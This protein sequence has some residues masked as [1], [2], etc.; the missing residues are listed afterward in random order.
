[1]KVQ[2][3]L[4]LAVAFCLLGLSCS[5]IPKSSSFKLRSYSEK[6][7]KNGL[8]VIFVSDREL[9]YISYSLIIQSGTLHEPDAY[10]GVATVVGELLGKGTQKGKTAVELADGFASMG[11]ELAVSTN[12]D[13][14]Y[15][16]A[17]SLA[18]FQ[19]PLLDLFSEAVILPSFDHR[20]ITRVKNQL[21]AAIKKKADDPNR[22]ADDAFATYLFGAHPYGRSTLGSLSGMNGIRKKQINSYYLKYYRPNNAIL[23]VVGNYDD[24]VVKQVEEKFGG[25]QARDVESSPLS[26]P[27][28]VTGREIRLVS[29][30]DLAQAQIHIGHL[31]ITRKNPDYLALRLANTILGSDFRLYQRIRVQLGLTYYISSSF[32][33]RL[34][35]GPFEISTFTRNEKIGETIGETIKVLEEFVNQGVSEDEVENAKKLVTGLFPQAIETPE[36]LALNLMLLRL[37]GIGDNYLQDFVSNIR[38]LSSSDIN[39][40]IKEY[41][42]PKNLKILVYAGEKSALPQL[43][44][45]G[46]VEVKRL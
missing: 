13:Y 27:P 32:E 14:T 35:R 18:Q 34:E 9:P 25:W 2:R 37:Y 26:S 10:A 31:G 24:N 6:K 36:K 44:P 20:E 7:L 15:L 33:A 17:G 46:L 3:I 28:E 21:V 8:R 1:M 43:R 30:A 38:R 40:V 11:A 41:V 19:E 29:R 45:I 5:S 4:L 23:A 22:F 42:H 16:R 39:R 12:Y